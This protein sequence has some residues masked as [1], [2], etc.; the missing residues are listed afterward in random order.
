MISDAIANAKMVGNQIILVLSMALPV[1]ISKWE[2]DCEAILAAWLPGQ[3]GGKAI[4]DI[5]L[6]VYNPTGKLCV[7]WPRNFDADQRKL[8]PNGR[9]VLQRASHPA[10]NVPTEIREGIFNGYKWYDAMNRNDQVRYPFGYG[11]SYTKFESEILSAKAVAYSGEDTGVDV[12]VRVR[13][14]GMI[15]GSEV[16]QL[17]IEAPDAGMVENAVYDPMVI[18]KSF[19]YVDKDGNNTQNMKQARYFPRVEGVQ[20]TKKQLCGF[21]KTHVLQPN[22]ETELIIHVAQRSLSYWNHAQMEYTERKDGP[23]DKWVTVF[24]T[25][26][27]RLANGSRISVEVTSQDTTALKISAPEQVAATMT[28][29]VTVAADFDTLGIQ[30]LNALDEPLPILDLHIVRTADLSRWEFIT[31]IQQ[32]GRMKI[33][34]REKEWSGWKAATSGPTITVVPAIPEIIEFCPIDE[35]VHSGDNAELR[36]VIAGIDENPVIAECD[37]TP[38]PIEVKEK[39]VKSDGSVEIILSLPC[40]HPEI[41]RILEAS[42]ANVKA[43]TAISVI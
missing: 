42:V 31:H 40:E 30:L 36:I 2:Q 23:L 29:P 12:R 27:F 20:F 43:R 5:L 34:A 17:Y 39:R 24:G 8:N 10:S 9:N 13:N 26:S 4:A 11:L 41:G 21:A 7:T 35:V 38:L 15:A 28:F 32:P 16:V 18:A 37:G 6:G 19:H 14:T 3:A 25:R 33:Q 22:E 1:D